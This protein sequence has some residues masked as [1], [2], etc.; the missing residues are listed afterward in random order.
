MKA[1]QYASTELRMAQDKLLSAHD[2]INT[3]D[4]DRARRLAEQAV[5]DAQLAQARGGARDAQHHADELRVTVD[6]LRAEAAR[7]II[8]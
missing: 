2:A 4:Y 7:P 6:A 5:I 3:A 1:P 8:P